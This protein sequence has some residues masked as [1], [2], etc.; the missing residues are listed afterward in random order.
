MSSALQGLDNLSGMSTRVARSM[1][2][3]A[4]QV[5]RDQ[6]KARV[7]VKSGK[8]K[9]AI[10]LA[11]RD[12]IS[13]DTRIVYSVT[14]NAK[15]A[16]HGHLVEFGHWRIN[17]LLRGEDGLWRATTTRLPQPVWVPAEP[18]LRPAYDASLARMGQVAMERGRARLAELLAGG[19]GDDEL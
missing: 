6:A 13:T 14:W 10:Y 19:G 2:V 5:V 4:G 17:E 11:Y 16:P 3:A 15:K 18:F 9:V 12:T 1:G 7:S 8:L